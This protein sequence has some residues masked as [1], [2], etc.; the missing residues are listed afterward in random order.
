LIDKSVIFMKK[1]KIMLVAIA[2]LATVGGALAFKASKAYSFDYCVRTIDDQATTLC[3]T[4][5][6]NSR[7]VNLGETGNL[8]YYTI[9]PATAECEDI[10]CSTTTTLKADL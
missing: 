8:Y 5:I 4:T 9:K 7:T 1:A 3:T 10:T 6:A 2:V